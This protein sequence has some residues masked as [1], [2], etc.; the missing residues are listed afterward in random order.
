MPPEP[1]FSSFHRAMS[2]WKS[3]MSRSG[4]LNR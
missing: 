2:A 4:V 3:A 1:P